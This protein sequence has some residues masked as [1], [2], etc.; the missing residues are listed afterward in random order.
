MTQLNTSRYNC[1]FV[2]KPPE[3]FIC[4]ICSNVAY[5]P[6]QLSCC[7]CICYSSCLLLK[8]KSCPKCC[9]QTPQ[10]FADGQTRKRI[11]RLKVV[12]SKQENGCKWSSQLV[13]LESH[14]KNCKYQEIE[15]SHCSDYVCRKDMDSHMS[16]T[17]PS[18]EYTCPDC[19]IAGTFTD[20]TSKH[21][22]NICPQKKVKCENGC[23]KLY[24][25]ANLKEHYSKCPEQKLSC[26]Y[27]CSV[28]MRKSDLDEHDKREHQKHLKHVALG[29]TSVQAHLKWAQREPVAVF[30]MPNFEKCNLNAEDWISEAF[31][32]HSNGYK[33]F[34]NVHPGGYG[35]GK[36]G[37]LSVFIYVAKGRNDESLPW[38][39]KACVYVQL[40]NQICDE[41]H[42]ST[43]IEIE[44]KQENIK[45]KNSKTGDI[46]GENGFGPHKFIEHDNLKKKEHNDLTVQYLNDDCLFFR[47]YV[48]CESAYKPWLEEL[49]RYK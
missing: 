35:R 9:E 16:D 11:E 37:Y 7:H 42:H 26:L 2:D 25:R 5:D 39:C 41:R 21:H 12:C 8:P 1:Q 46:I 10:S 34:L 22:D 28:S 47:V 36:D 32:S 14:L 6:H 30:K 29:V 18:R 3:D 24:P 48:L 43:S 44:E 19:H 27:G 38:P 17:C 4:S 40:L 15:C 45:C 49:N 23:K 13:H 20:I 31:H 33:L